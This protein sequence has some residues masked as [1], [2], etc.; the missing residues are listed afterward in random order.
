MLEA[1]VRNPIPPVDDW[2]ASNEEALSNLREFLQQAHVAEAKTW[3]DVFKSQPPRKT[4]VRL[5]SKIRAQP[6]STSLFWGYRSKREFRKEV[7]RLLLWYVDRKR[8]KR[9]RRGRLLRGRRIAVTIKVKKH[10][11][12]MCGRS[13]LQGLWNWRKAAMWIRSSKLALRSGTLPVE[14]FWSVLQGYL[15][16]AARRLSTGYL[17]VICQMAYVRFNW[18]LYSSRH[19]SSYSERDAMFEQKLHVC[20]QILSQMCSGSALPHLRSLVAPFQD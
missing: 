20:H 5:C 13:T 9:L 11:R 16:P 2:R 19:H 3:A 10:L 14:R 6:H 12:R 7:R 4:I 15:P 17:A 1:L 18:H 8:F